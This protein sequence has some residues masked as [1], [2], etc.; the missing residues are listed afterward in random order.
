MAVKRT[1]VERAYD[2]VLWVKNQPNRSSALY[3]RLMQ[4]GGAGVRNKNTVIK[5]TPN[6]LRY[7][8]RTP[9]ARRAI[10]TI[11]NPV[12]NLK[13]EIR[14]KKGLA[15]NSELQRQI[16]IVTNCFKI[17]NNDDSFQTFCEKL[18]E[19]FLTVSGGAYEQQIVASMTDHPLYMWNVDS[20]SLQI[21][22]LWN[23]NARSIRYRQTIGTGNVSIQTVAQL[24]D[25]EIVYIAPNPSSNTPYGYGP[26]EIA[27]RSINRHL[28]TGEYAG[29]VASNAQPENL[30]WLGNV[31]TAEIQSFRQYWRN[32]VE[33]LGQTPLIGGPD[34][35]KAL[36]L[37]GGND[38]ALYLKWQQLLIREIATAFDLSELNFNLGGSTN[39]G[40]EDGAAERDWETAVKPMALI[41]EDFFTRQTIE[42]RLGFTQVEFGFIG[43]DREEEEAQARIHELQYQNNM[44]T[45]NEARA[46]V[47]MPPSDSEWADLT[48]ADVQIAIGEAR[49]GG[50]NENAPDKL[51][52]PNPVSSRKNRSS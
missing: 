14:P 40:A 52:N 10:N 3:P 48:Y 15:I 37:Q 32:E 18:I 39:Q 11:K 30:L 4:L 45:P 25:E 34:E 19:D 38:E 20:M 31:G 13:W 49:R 50:V 24:S 9:I 41:L 6:N 28:G 5:P 8:A 29:N 43:L 51:H 26:L 27:A 33:G 35:P 21:Y 22:P 46:Q 47:G 42:K 36:R 16:N 12:K 1:F 2:L 44:I 23:G 7:F 17:P